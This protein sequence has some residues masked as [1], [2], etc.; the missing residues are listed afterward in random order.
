M[1]RD[2][3]ASFV[4]RQKKIVLGVALTTDVCRAAR[5]AHKLQATS[6][7]ALGRLLTATAQF[8]LI[9]KKPGAVSLQIVCQGRLRQMFADLTPEGHLRGYA[10]VPDL[11]LPP[12]PEEDPRGRRTVKAAVVQG[13]LSVIRLGEGTTFSQSSVDLS[14]GEV[15]RDVENFLGTSDQIPSVVA[16]E[17]LLG[18]QGEVEQAG[19]V[20]VQA[21][22]QADLSALDSMRERLADDTLVRLL[23]Q[24]SGEPNAFAAAL[25]PEAHEIGQRVPLRWQCRCSSDRLDTALK[26]IDPQEL[27]EMVDEKK[28]VQVTC[29]F[30]HKVYTVSPDKL[31]EV[32]LNT[33][34]ARG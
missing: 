20:I 2:V 18:E 11:D 9:Q 22:P 23:K 3:F 10:K 6:C 8:G 21:L 1:S 28:N 7:I 4:D 29:D 17:V 16:C 34:T 30:C 14:S 31:E 32:F 5:S 19:G 24:Y 26:M 33:I 15:D 12:L 27:A 13:T 25:L